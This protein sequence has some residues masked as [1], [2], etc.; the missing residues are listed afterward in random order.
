MTTITT[1]GIFVPFASSRVQIDIQRPHR[2][3][4]YSPRLNRWTLR[5][6]EQYAEHNGWIMRSAVAS[7]YIYIWWIQPK[8][9]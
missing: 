5:V 4:A 3:K 9:R 2:L 6:I 1:I 8:R 7:N